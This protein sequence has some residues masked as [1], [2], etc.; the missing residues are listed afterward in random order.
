MNHTSPP[1]SVALL[2]LAFFLCLTMD[3]SHANPS[4]L[5]DAVAV[6]RLD[7][8]PNGKGGPISAVGKV[9]LGV[10]LTGADLEMALQRGRSGKVAVFNGGYLKAGDEKS[11]TPNLNGSKETTLCMRMRDPEGAWNLPIFSNDDPNNLSSAI[12]YGTLDNSMIGTRE[13]KRLKDANNVACVKFLWQG[14]P[15]AQRVLPE[16]IEK[17]PAHYYKTLTSDKGAADNFLKGKLKVG[18]PVELIHPG[19]WHDIIVRFT[20]PRVEMFIDGVLVDEEFPHGTVQNL[21]GTFLIGAG[22][23]D[24]QFKSGFHGQV[25]YV[26]MW[27]R[28][29]TNKE[30]VALSGGEKNVARRDVEIL[31]EKNTALEGSNLQYWRPRGYNTFVGDCMTFSHDG[32]FHLFYLFD[33]RHCNSKWGMGAHQFA[34]LSTRDLVHWQEHPM[35]IPI[36]SQTECAIGT[37]YF[38]YHNGTYYA[39]YIQHGRRCLYKDAPYKADNIFVATSQ[40]GIHFTKKP[41]PVATPCYTGEGDINPVV[42]ADA[43]YKHFFMNLDAVKTYTSDDLLNWTETPIPSLNIDWICPCIFEWNGW[44]YYTGCGYYKKSRTPPEVANWENPPFQGLEDGLA[45]P[46]VAKFKDDRY[47]LAGFD[48]CGSAYAHQLVFRELTQ[49]KDGTLGMKWPAELIPKTGDPIHYSTKTLGGEVSTEGGIRLAAASGTAAVLLTDLPDNVRI[50]TRV[51]PGPGVKGF[52]LFCRGDRESTSGTEIR[53]DPE[54]QQVTCGRDLPLDH[55]AQLQWGQRK[56][57]KASGLG[58]SFTLDIIL[59]DNIVDFCIDNRRTGIS[60]ING[61]GDP[62]YHTERSQGH[63]TNR[64]FLYAKHGQVSFENLQIRPL[65]EQ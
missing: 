5:D 4:P 57:E 54:F 13:L 6:W 41:Q 33:R 46:M 29:I 7:G 10:P 30:I 52:G 64:V 2:G 9:T 15:L 61:L 14:E 42:F 59:K 49:E 18:I 17:D 27:N 32:V 56:I 11:Q 28:A 22:Y 58:Q 16:Y 65:I 1:F 25:D 62:S 39:Y 63:V 34:H 38:I 47:I 37:G 19:D 23:V 40:D 20:G 8:S 35:A 31:G 36:T 44:H 53:F 60:A 51:N 3:R 43:A 50:T 55:N 48:T 21:K 24:G 12:L 26:A 45:V